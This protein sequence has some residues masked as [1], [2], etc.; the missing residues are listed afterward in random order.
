MFPLLRRFSLKKRSF[1]LRP[2]KKTTVELMRAIEDAITR[3]E[4]YFTD[5]GEKRSRA[6]KKVNDLEVI[7]ILSGNDK[8]HEAV[9]DKFVRNSNDWNY[10][11]RGI[12]SDGDQIRIVISFDREGMPIITVI[13][14]DEED[15]E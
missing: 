15:D 11:I 4:Y 14:L 2:S 10:H 1:P 7:K 9:K 13:N 5:H 6:R 8:W 3:G 12:N